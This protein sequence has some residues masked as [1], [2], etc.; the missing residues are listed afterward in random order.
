MPTTAPPCRNCDR[1]CDYQV[2]HNAQ[3]R[4]WYCEECG[5]RT[6]EWLNSIGEEKYVPSHLKNDYEEE[7]EEDGEDRQMLFGYD[8]DGDADEEDIF[9]ERERQTSLEEYTDEE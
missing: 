4:V 7:D 3:D 5:E 9:P 8:Y 6:A 1:A 2:T